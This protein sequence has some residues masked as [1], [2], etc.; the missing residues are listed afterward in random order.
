MPGTDLGLRRVSVHAGTA[1]VDL[2]LPAGVPVAVLMPSIIDILD[3]RGSGDPEAGRYRLSRPGAAAFSASTTLAQHSIRDGEVLVLTESATP[4]PGPRYE[5]TAEA[6]AALLDSTAHPRGSLLPA[7]RLSGAIV[8]SVLTGIGGL[9]LIRKAFTTNVTGATLGI[10]VSAGLVALL[11]ARVAHRGYGD[12]SAG[13]ALSV[14][15]TVFTAA[16]GYL[17]V[18]GVPGL[19]NV[20]LGAMTAAVTSVLALRV[21]GCGAVTLTALACVATLVAAAAFAGVITAAPPHVIGSVSALVSLGLLGV[22]ARLSIALAGLSPQL[23]PAPDLD[24]RAIRA[25]TW[26]TSLLAAFACGLTVGAVVTV[27]TGAPGPPRIVFG[28]LAGALLMLRARRGDHR[29]G[30]VFAACGTAVLATTFAIIGAGAPSGAWI[31]AMTAAVSTAALC[32][33][34]AASAASPSPV[35]RRVIDVLEGVALIAMVPS[36]CWVCGLYGAVRALNLT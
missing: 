33:G 30:M 16:A 13:L 36:T 31:A 34:C 28:A 4:P 7:P 3:G 1:A 2:A 14:I 24:A 19:P 35:L 29:G 20:V 12:A 21:S 8:A 9:T 32:L 22:A 27:L 26:L 5:D 11:C 17:A 23:P 15:A 25:G 6:V 10:T 18:P